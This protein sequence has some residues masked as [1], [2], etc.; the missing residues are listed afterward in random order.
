MLYSP[1]GVAFAFMANQIGK[2]WSVADLLQF[3]WAKREGAFGRNE[4]V[5]EAIRV[6]DGRLRTK[7]RAVGI[8]TFNQNR[9]EEQSRG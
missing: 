4:A 2:I 9:Q 3:H 6:F 8:Q 5:Q 7:G 1:A